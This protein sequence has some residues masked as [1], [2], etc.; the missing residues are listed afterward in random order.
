MSCKH[1]FSYSWSDALDNAVQQEAARQYPDG[2]K[3][4]AH[5]YSH[6]WKAIT[7]AVNEGI[8]SHLEAIQFKLGTGEYGK[9]KITITP[10][11]LHVLV[12]RLMECNTTDEDDYDETQLLAGDICETL[13]IELT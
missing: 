6:E 13:D 3:I 12:R 8:D 7:R 5:G 1:C 11:T 2:Y 10:E 4:E 9:R